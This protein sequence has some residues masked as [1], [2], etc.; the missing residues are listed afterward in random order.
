M[1]TIEWKTFINH[2]Y[3]LNFMAGRVL[4]QVFYLLVVQSSGL[5]EYISPA[6][7]QVLGV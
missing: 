3:L 6:Y 1:V 5:I 7:H 4:F 2:K